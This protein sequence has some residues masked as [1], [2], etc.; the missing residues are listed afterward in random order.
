MSTT[1]AAV[2]VRKTSILS[3]LLVLFL[4]PS[5]AS[6][7]GTPAPSPS[8]EVAPVH[9]GTIAFALV[10]PNNLDDIYL[11]HTDGTGLTRLTETNTSAEAPA[12]SPDGTKIAY[13]MCPCLPEDASRPYNV[14][15]M[16]ADG[17]EKQQ[18]THGPLGGCLPAWSPDGTKIAFSTM[19][20]EEAGPA[21][22]YVMNSDGINPQRVTNGPAHDLF[23]SWAPNGT[24]VFLRKARTFDSSY[25][26][27]FAGLDSSF[28]AL[29][30]INPDGSGLVS[31]SAMDKIGGYA[32]SP[33][34][35]KIAIH[36]LEQHRIVILPALANSTPVTLVDTDFGFNFIKIAWSPDGKALALAKSALIGYEAL[37]LHIVNADGSGLVTVPN[38]K[39]VMD[40]AWR[41]Q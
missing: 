38:A 22:I 16:N 41:P 12:W 23:P 32:L 13:H 29:F 33:D 25:T 3:L 30:A 9:S 40:V 4:A 11:I 21:Q 31:L 26:G 39:A 14:W 17:S 6:R 15:V 27:A 34:G 36:D 10:G 19:P 7:Q 24:I 2:R 28:G 18:L 5:C 1:C 8:T 35:N 37:E 20:S